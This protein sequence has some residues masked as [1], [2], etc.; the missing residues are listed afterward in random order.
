M[1]KKYEKTGETVQQAATRANHAGALG[2]DRLKASER[3]RGEEVRQRDQSRAKCAEID[4]A[5][6]LALKTLKQKK[7]RRSEVEGKLSQA[8]AE[9]STEKGRGRKLAAR[10]AKM[11]KELEAM[12]VQVDE[13]RKKQEK[14]ERH[15]GIS[16]WRLQTPP[17]QHEDSTYRSRNSATSK[18]WSWCG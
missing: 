18:S 16:S 1:E 5:R 14:I 9:L 13:L 11:A 7:G 6:R 12:R 4:D 8:R 10:E 17:R 15:H 2:R 3:S